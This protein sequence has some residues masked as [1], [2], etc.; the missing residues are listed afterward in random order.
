MTN[1]AEY[2]MTLVTPMYNEADGIQGNLRNILEALEALNINYEYILIDDG[3]TDDSHEKA[4]QILNDLPTCRIIHYEKNR[5]RGYALRQGIYNARGKYI[6]TTESDLSWSAEITAKLYWAL[7]N[8]GSDVVV[9]SVYMPGGGLENVPAFRHLLSRYSN[10]FMRWSFGG[11]LTMLS[12]MTRGYRR[13][14]VQSLYLEEDN[15]EIHL[16]I[17]AKAQAKNF[18]ITEIPAVIRWESQDADKP[19]KAG[20][21]MLR[22]V[23]PHLFVSFKQAA[24]RM[25]FWGAGITGIIGFFLTISGI[26]NKLFLIT[27]RPL[28]YLVTYGLVFIV[29]S[30]LFLLFGIVSIQVTYLYRSMV[31]I[32]S[33]IYELQ[34]ILKQP[35]K[36]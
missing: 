12:G 30:M 18:T 9:A 2:D 1:H 13:E 10:K 35:E 29:I 7:L 5:G 28:P 4:K 21:G 36:D 16:E 26:I 22:F 34:N 32:Q 27:S 6:I 31:H 33:Q 11:N 17:I 14:S 3:S 8:T 19:R 25:F 23:I 15:K 20:F 24:V